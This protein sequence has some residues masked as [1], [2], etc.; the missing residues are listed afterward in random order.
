MSEDKA[1]ASARG[2]RKHRT[3]TAVRDAR[4]KTVVVSV[5]RRVQHPL[6][7]KTMRQFTTFYAH[8]EKNEARAGDRVRIVE[9][10]PMSRLKRWRVI[11]VMRAAV[12]PAGDQAP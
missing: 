10:R 4:D 6:Y 5:E 12:A 1:R 3:G 8:D 9:T 11:E 2:T 7:G